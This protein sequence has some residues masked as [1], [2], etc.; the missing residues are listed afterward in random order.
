MKTHE[1]KIKPEYFRDVVRGI[2]TFEVRQNDRNFGVGDIITLRE[3]ENDKFLGNFVNVEIVYILDDEEYCKHDYVV[4]GFKL[5][6]D[7]GGI[8]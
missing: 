3:F 6:L 4:L 1:L 2:K 5:R 8:L 7:L